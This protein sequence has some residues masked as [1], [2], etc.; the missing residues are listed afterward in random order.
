M[1]WKHTPPASR[2]SHQPNPARDLF[3][4]RYWPEVRSF[5]CGKTG[6]GVADLVH[7]WGSAFG[8]FRWV[9]LYPRGCEDHMTTLRTDTLGDG[10][11]RRQNENWIHLKE[12]RLPDRFIFSSFLL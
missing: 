1:V 7:R 12:L 9:Y 10:Y 3:D 4:A 6:S 2:S 8:H 11:R 5:R